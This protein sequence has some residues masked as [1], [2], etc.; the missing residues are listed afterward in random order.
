MH[1]VSKAIVSAA[2]VIALLAGSAQAADPT[3]RF[4]ESG[5]KKYLRKNYA[6]AVADFDKHLAANPSDSTV[7]LLRGLSK[8]LL[9]PEDVAGACADFL[10]VKSG[11]KDMNVETYCAGQPGW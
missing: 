11:L 2:L 3:S 8:S 7:V 6:G 9:N 4:K 5:M 1:L 10:V